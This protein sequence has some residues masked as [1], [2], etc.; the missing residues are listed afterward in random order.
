MDVPPP[1]PARLA[2]TGSILWLLWVF[3]SGVA[4]GVI[5]SVIVWLYR[6][7]PVRQLLALGDLADAWMRVKQRRQDISDEQEGTGT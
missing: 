6:P 7:R 5:L 3:A 2:V 4:L 1:G